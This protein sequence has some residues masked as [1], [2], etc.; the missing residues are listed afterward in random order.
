MTSVFVCVG[1]SAL[2]FSSAPPQVAHATPTESL[3]N[4]LTLDFMC[5]GCH[6]YE[7]NALAID[8]PPH[9]P[10][11]YFGT[12][13]ANAARDPV[14]WAGVALASDDYPGET[15]DCVRCHSPR[16]FLEGRGD[17]IAV[18]E[19]LPPDLDS[20]SCEVCHRAIDDGETP[21][22]NARYVLDDVLVDG[23]PPRRG[24]WDYSDPNGPELPPHPIIQDLDFLPSSRMCGTCHDVSTGRGRVDDQGASMGVPFNEQRTYSEWL[25]SA[26][27]QPGDDARTCQ[28]CHMA[29]VEV[30]A[31]GCLEYE[32]LSHHDDGSARRHLILG[33]NKQALQVI[34]DNSPGA[35]AN[36]IDVAISLYDDFLATAATLD[37]EFPAAVD[38]AVGV[39]ALA[40][41]VT[42]ETGHKLPS[43]YSEG[44]VMWLEV[45]ASYAGELVWSS[46][47]WDGESIESDD[48]LR[49]YEGVAE[50]WSDGTRNHLLLNDHW[51]LDTRIPAKGAVQNLETDPVGDRYTL[52]PDDTWPN[53]DDHSY[54]FAPASVVDV[55]PDDASDDELELSVRLLYLINTPSYLDQL[56]DDNDV[57]DAG[58]AVH[59]M[60]MDDGGPQPVVLGA[61]TVTVPLTG[62]E[63]PEPGDGDGDPGD[64]DG[65]GDPGDGDSGDSE[66]GS[67]S[68]ATTD[69]TSTD[70][71]GGSE[72]GSGCSCSTRDSGPPL[73]VGLLSLVLLGLRRRR[74]RG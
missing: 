37:V 13:M 59:D 56:R 11:A 26:Y 69:A 63:Q 74:S 33:A 14:F 53:Y 31:A 23:Q 43:G 9:A 49:T 40:V 29:T 22:G 51:V 38:L 19:L 10:A 21:P 66:G 44:R 52:L 5:S 65:D 36:A 68:G 61:A 70:S 72:E 48:Q 57:N 42:N 3:Q 67:D 50:R 6:E 18:D 46:G 35:K 30:P 24:P 41:R 2:C 1:L 54:S 62:L 20:V 25:G 17:A 45:T 58:Q 64:G 55:T 32:N 16:A 12:L 8:L 7:N 39:D 4:P 71:A 27:A 15:E 60:Y 28:D 34:A 47:L 73:S